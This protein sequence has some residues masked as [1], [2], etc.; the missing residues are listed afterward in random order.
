MS[1]NIINGPLVLYRWIE[2]L[3]GWYF[4]GS[5][6]GSLPTET[7]NDQRVISEDE[8]NEYIESLEETQQK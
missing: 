6:D 8:Y 4:M 2:D 3:D 1:D 7:F 5:S